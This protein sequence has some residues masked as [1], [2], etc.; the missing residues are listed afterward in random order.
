MSDLRLQSQ[1]MAAYVSTGMTYFSSFSIKSDETD[2]N[3]ETC[4]FQHS[5]ISSICELNKQIKYHLFLLMG[6][7]VSDSLFFFFVRAV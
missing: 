4:N 1:T 6:T 2:C 7:E 3:P 5:I